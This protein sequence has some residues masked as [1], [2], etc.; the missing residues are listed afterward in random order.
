MTL[1]L[2]SKTKVITIT[3]PLLK[4]TTFQ[5]SPLQARR[6]VRQLSVF[7]HLISN[8]ETTEHSDLPLLTAS[9][10]LLQVA[11]KLFQPISLTAF[12]LFKP[13]QVDRSR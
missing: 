11:S 7:V 4:C 9:Y 3:K 1:Q 12:A 13:S 10:C 5:M 2:V 8:V 6:K